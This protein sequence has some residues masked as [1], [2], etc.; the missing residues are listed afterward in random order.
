MDESHSAGRKF[1]LLRRRRI[2][3]GRMAG[4]R[5]TDAEIIFQREIVDIGAVGDMGFTIKKSE[6]LGLSSWWPRLSCAW[7]RS[8]GVTVGASC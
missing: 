6:T 3:R 7:L 1:V 5:R 4:G 2:G 8:L